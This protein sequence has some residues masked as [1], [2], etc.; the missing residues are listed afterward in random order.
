[1]RTFLALVACAISAAAAAQLP[2]G[3]QWSQQNYINWSTF[4][5]GQHS[6]I[7]EQQVIEI[8]TE[9]DFMNYWQRSTGNA[10]GT[11]PKGID[12]MKQKLVAVHLG[13]RPNSG[14]SVAVKNIVRSGAW[15]TIHAVEETPMSGVYVAQVQ[16]S[17]WVLVKLD[18]T[19]AAFR[20]EWSSRT[21]RPAIILGPGGSY[22]GP[23]DNDGAGWVDPKHQADWGTYRQGQECDITTPEFIVMHT[24]HDFARYYQRAF[25]GPVPSTSIDWN[26]YKLVAIHL[27]TRETSGYAVSVRNVIKNGAY[28]VVR[29]VEETPVPGQF[30]NRRA[31]SPFVVIKVER[32]LV[33]MELDISVQQSKRGIAFGGG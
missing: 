19:A 22:I 24:I 9:G 12:W 11:A 31:T 10:P 2:G 13:T 15:A 14:Y 27:G 17:P 18:R 32:N 33:Q 30:V 3:A 25:R 29:A 23:K 28:G 21:A 1:M 26:K 20:T 8:A 5:Q 7:S 6:R 16:V 4:K